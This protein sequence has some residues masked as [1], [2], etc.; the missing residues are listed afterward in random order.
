[1]K[2]FLRLRVKYQNK[3]FIFEQCEEK[4]CLLLHYAAQGGSILIV[5]EILENI[6]SDDILEYKCMQGETALRFA[7]KYKQKD[8]AQHLIKMHY[9]RVKKLRQEAKATETERK[10]N[11][12]NVKDDIKLVTLANKNAYK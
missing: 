12:R 1:M 9:K 7:I 5:D 8:V 11:S 6:S 10:G 2:F 4:R 3:G